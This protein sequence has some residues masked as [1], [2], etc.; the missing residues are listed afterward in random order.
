MRLKKNIPPAT[1]LIAIVA[2]AIATAGCGSDESDAMKDGNSTDA[3]FV[4]EMTAHHKSAIEMAE[5][6]EKQAEHPEIKKLA[7]EITSSQQSEIS[8]MRRIGDE[9]RAHGATGTSLGMSDEQMGMAMD[10]P[11]LS[12]ATPFD[13]AFIDM[14]IP[15]HRGAIA[16]ANTEIQKGSHSELQK[17]AKNIIVAQT[18]EIEQMQSWRKEW[19][20]EELVVT[21]STGGSSGASGS[22]SHSAH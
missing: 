21:P 19:F 15:H 7:S 2:V 10:G 11:M 13:R 1:A 20:G 4:T 9:L 6:A 5:I 14:M 3:A 17:I 16:M 18:R 22:A 12:E 8:V